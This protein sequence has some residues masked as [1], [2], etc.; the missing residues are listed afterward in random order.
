MLTT[1]TDTDA[2]DVLERYA[3]GGV[4]AVWQALGNAGGFSG[5]RI[6]RGQGADGSDLCLRAWPARRMTPDRLGTIHRAMNALAELPFI[7]QLYSTMDEQTWVEAGD[8]TLWE[9]TS[10]LPGQA[11]FHQRPTSARLFA[12]MRALAQVHERLRPA[13]P[14]Y[15][16]C[17][18][19]RRLLRALRGWRDLS[20][21]GWVPDFSLPRPEGIADLARRAW[22]ALSVGA[23]S[24]EFSLV[25]WEPRVMPL[26]LCLCDIWHDHVLFDQD[27]VTGV[28]D[29]GAVKVDCVAVDLA[30]LLG[31]MIPDEIERMRDAL[32]VYSKIHPVNDQVLKLAEAI[33]RAGS[34]VGLTNWLRWLYLEK[35]SYG[36]V[37]GVAQRM[38]A[39]LKRVESPRPMVLTS[40]LW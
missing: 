18:A 23:Y 20:Q 27:T 8:E 36:E 19:V 29:F 24:V 40:F 21:S 2:R 3:P 16:P 28:I 26:Q 37:A 31:S 32:T 22:N 13:K 30:R 7:P 34:F 6:W 5:A 12:A 10:W 17:P 15:G 25:E 4:D 35:R 14:A 39:L 33:D 1:L 9:V 11:D 38:T